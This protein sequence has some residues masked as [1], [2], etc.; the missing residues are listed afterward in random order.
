MRIP[1]KV[2]VPVAVV[3]SLVAAYAIAGFWWAP[4]YIRAEFTRSVSQDLGKRPRLGEVKVGLVVRQVVVVDA[5]DLVPGADPHDVEVVEDVELRDGEFG[6]RVEPHGVAQHDGVEPAG[7][8]TTAGV[9]AEL[10]AD[11]DDVFADFVEQFGGE[12]SGADAGDV[13]L[14]DAEHPVDVAG[15]DAGAGHAP[16]ATG[17]DDVT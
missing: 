7:P 13:R 16:P 8:A 9:G 12:R 17:F 2:W 14:R 6:Q 4:R 3:A 15:A 11:G 1:K 10:A 5:V